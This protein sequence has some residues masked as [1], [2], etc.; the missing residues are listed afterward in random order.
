MMQSRPL[1]TGLVLL[2]VVVPLPAA[3]KGAVQVLLE[4]EIIGPHLASTE[5]ED[6]LD[7]HI[8]R[9]PEVTS[10]AAWE[11]EAERIRT[12]VLDRVVYRG[13]AGRWRDADLGVDWQETIPGGPGYRIKK[14]R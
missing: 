3:E 12:G 7:A 4:Q 11:K 14:L 9:L 1:L 5:V 6:Y 8:P 13:E 2:G 10:Q